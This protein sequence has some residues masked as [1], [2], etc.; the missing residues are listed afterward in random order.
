MSHA[1]PVPPVKSF[2]F[3]ELIG[4]EGSFQNVAAFVSLDSMN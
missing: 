4:F 2:I 3:Q 1:V